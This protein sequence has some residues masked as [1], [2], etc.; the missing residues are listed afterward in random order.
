MDSTLE[1]EK[2]RNIPIKYDREVV[3]STVS[4]VSRIQEIKARREKAFYKNRMLAAK[5]VSLRTDALEV[6]SGS[7]LLGRDKD[8]EVV[9]KALL[10]AEIKAKKKEKR[11]LQKLETQVEEMQQ[12][13]DE[14]QMEVSPGEMTAV[15]GV[16]KK[17]KIKVPAT[18]KRSKGLSSRSSLVP[19]GDGGMRMGMGM[20]LD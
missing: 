3:A 4:A 9:K 16:R 2:R 19:A 12:E 13:V 6:L 18:K 1:F 20:Q 15:E 14:G 8:S 7:H 11:R 17:M 10:A 5:P